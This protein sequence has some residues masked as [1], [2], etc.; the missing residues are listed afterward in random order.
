MNLVTQNLNPTLLPAVPERYL[1]GFRL[2][3]RWPYGIKW[4]EVDEDASHRIACA[5]MYYETLKGIAGIICPVP[6]GDKSHT[7]L[8][9]PIQVADKYVLQRYMIENNCDVAIQHAANCADLDAY[10]AYRRDCPAARAAYNGTLMKAG[11]VVFRLH[12]PSAMHTI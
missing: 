1:C 7:F 3:K 9:Y 4:N 8:Y 11:I 6:P 5:E 2:S 10:K 12:R